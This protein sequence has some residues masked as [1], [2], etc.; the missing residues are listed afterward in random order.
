MIDFLEIKKKMMKNNEKS[1]IQTRGCGCCS[2]GRC[3]GSGRGCGSC[4][5]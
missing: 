3:G 1:K 4:V 2:C 5:Y